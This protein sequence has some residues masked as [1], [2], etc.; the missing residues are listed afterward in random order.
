MNTEKVDTNDTLEKP[1]CL[2]E[3]RI[4]YRFFYGSVPEVGAVIDKASFKKFKLGDVE[5]T[6]WSP[7]LRPYISKFFDKMSERLN[8]TTL[9][10]LICFEYFIMGNC[11]TFAEDNDLPKDKKKNEFD[12]KLTYQGWKKIL[13][14]PL[15]QVRVKRIPLS[16]DVV[17]DYVPD[18]ETLKFLK[19]EKKFLKTLDSKNQ[20]PLDQNPEL[21]SFAYLFTRKIAQYNTLGISVIEKYMND[22]SEKKKIKLKI[23][24]AEED[25]LNSKIKKFIEEFLFKPVAIK[26]GFVGPEVLNFPV[27]YPEVII[28]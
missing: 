24:E 12:S 18:P 3:R 4:F 22:L 6:W 2:R 28:I 15:D 27:L 1:Q 20:V 26:K 5:D 9:I 19:K 10:N 16:E 14:L 21:G 25:L 8:L 7:G 13:I 23:F 11:V 17:L